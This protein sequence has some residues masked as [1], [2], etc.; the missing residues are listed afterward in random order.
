MHAHRIA[1]ADHLHVVLGK[2]FRLGRR[3]GESPDS[4]VGTLERLQHS[5]REVGAKVLAYNRGEFAGIIART[6][7][8]WCPAPPEAVVSCAA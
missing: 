8:Q 4:G 1:A 6:G 3:G 5:G 2:P 7:W